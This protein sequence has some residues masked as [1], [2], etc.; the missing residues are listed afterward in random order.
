MQIVAVEFDGELKA[1]VDARELHRFLNS[2]QEFQN[3]YKALD[4]VSK[5]YEKKNFKEFASYPTAK[6]RPR[7]D[8]AISR[9]EAL[10][11]IMASKTPEGEKVREKTSEILAK[12][13]DS[14]VPMNLSTLLSLLE[15]TRKL[16]FLMKAT[17][18]EGTWKDIVDFL[19]EIYSIDVSFL[20]EFGPKESYK[21]QALEVLADVESAFECR[22]KKGILT[23]LERK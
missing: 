2:K 12:K 20:E 19:R 8:Y 14:N 13:G 17:K 18:K 1:A 11:I 15:D 21:A 22:G 3:W 5:T 16:I 7:K 23:K 9:D 6:G 4:K 10:K